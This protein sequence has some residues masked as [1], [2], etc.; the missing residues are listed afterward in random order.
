VAAWLREYLRGRPGGVPI[1]GKAKRTGAMIRADLRRAKAQWIREATDPKTRR[2]RRDADFLA[3]R[4]AAGRVADFML[5]G[6][7]P[8]SR[9]LGGPE[10]R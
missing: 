9:G 7:T 10:C 3:V 5:R 8:T 4:D 6:G 1:W 2:E